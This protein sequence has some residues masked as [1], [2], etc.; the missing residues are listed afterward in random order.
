MVDELRKSGIDLIGDVSWGTH[1]CQFYQTKEDLID[2][3]VPY[4]KE[5]LENNE[6]CMWVTSEPLSADEAENAMRNALP[7]VDRYFKNGQIEIIPYSDWYVK[8]GSFN[9]DRVLNGWIDKLNNGLMKGFEGLRLSGNTFWL[10]KE[11]WDDFVSY[12]TEVDKVIDSFKMIAM[13]TY[14]LDKCNANEIIDVINNHQ[15]AL[16]KREGEWTLLES[17][18]QKKIEEE[19][20]ESKYKYLSLFDNML[21]GYAHCEMIYD[22][23]GNPIDFIYLNVN[24]AF[25]RLTG[26][27]DVEG[28][29]IS[30]IIPQTKETH[31]ELLEIYG[32]VAST[33][34]PEKFEIEFKPLDRW[35][36]VAVYSPQKNHF[37]A[38]FENITERKDADEKLNETLKNYSQLNQT[39]IALR[40]SSQVMMHATDETDYLDNLCKI[41]IDDCGHSMVW[42]GITEEK[43]K[44]V[45]PVAY[46]GFEEE[47]IKTLDITYEDTERGQGPTGTAIRTGKPCIC[48][49][50]HIDPKFKPWREEALKRG[51]SSSIV[52][53]LISGDKVFGALNI[54]SKETNPFSEEEKM[55]L[56][57]LAD[58]IS[59]GIT[60][61]RYRTAH[62][63]AEK[64]LRKSFKEVERSNA[65]LEQ[66]AYVTSHDLREPLRMISSFLQL[67]ERRYKDQLDQDANEF[68]GYAVDGAK[69][70]DAMINDILIYSRVANK[71]KKFTHVH[72]DKVLDE[73]YLNLKTSIEETNAE[74]F[75]D[76]LPTIMIDEHLMIQLFQNLIGNAIKYR[77]E[78]K[79]KIY[80][81]SYKE[82]KQWLFSVKDNGI[83]ISQEYLDKIFT[84]FQRLHTNEE[85]DGTG[86]GLA[87]A[88]KIV[89]Q[90]GGDIWA[91]SEL[92]EGST[93]YF[94]I[95]EQ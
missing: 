19:L 46:A 51:Y 82:D 32:K 33:G 87:I 45:I 61:L 77:S 42:I 10:E 49:N 8:E 50:M 16:I 64:A 79:P 86:I 26:L 36:T 60:S 92:G 68:I 48:E 83:G 44:K 15:F 6:F 18:K 81:S 70:L 22:N 62:D 28:K 24:E 88:Q 95:P 63:K 94:T 75:N 5:G 54:Y 74:I 53:P 4:F 31:P 93:F 41:I 72:C 38:V 20:K 35:F 37:I 12:E 65:E 84:I 71:E 73:A 57:E 13:C 89:H 1:F 59:Y 80:I 78:N 34:K 29:K 2:I 39:L 56:K 27:S 7:E 58:D 76:P 14:C 40:D 23:Q 47:Y 85:Y 30:E 90:H 55:L 17:S 69:R 43:G 9:S 3:L 52:L 91:E 25:E 21:D 11:D 67:L 66:F